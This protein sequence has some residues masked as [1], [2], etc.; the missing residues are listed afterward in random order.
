MLLKKKPLEIQNIKILFKKKYKI[1][2]KSKL[3]IKITKSIIL[4]KE[5]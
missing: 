4:Y 5:Y 1:D 3:N 2:I